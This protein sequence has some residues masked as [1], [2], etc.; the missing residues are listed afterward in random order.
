MA[1]GQSKLE[2]KKGKKKRRPHQITIPVKYGGVC[3]GVCGGLAVLGGPVTAATEWN[4]FCCCPR[5][6]IFLIICHESAFAASPLLFSCPFCSQFVRQIHSARTHTHTHTNMRVMGMKNTL[7]D[8]WNQWSWLSAG[9]FVSQQFF[10]LLSVFVFVCASFWNSISSFFAADRIYFTVIF[11]L[12]ESPSALSFW[13]CL[14]ACLCTLPNSFLFSSFPPP[15]SPKLNR[16]IIFSRLMRL[17]ACVCIWV[18]GCVCV[19]LYSLSLSFSPF[20]PQLL[21]FPFALSNRPI[22]GHLS[23]SLFPFSIP[24]SSFACQCA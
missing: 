14:F 22:P 3:G 15:C 16:Q 11:R 19:C 9:L 17:C 10:L 4:A 20:L 24:Q 8:H 2:N 5:W 21:Y 13:L 18:W 12:T 6:I 7:A 23:I 1:T